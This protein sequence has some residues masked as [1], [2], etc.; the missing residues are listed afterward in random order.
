MKPGPDRI[1]DERGNGRS[2][3]RFNPREH[4]VDVLA[5]TN[6]DH[7]AARFKTVRLQPF[8]SRL[9]PPRA[10]IHSGELPSLASEALRNGEADSARCARHDA[11]T[12]L[13]PRIQARALCGASPKAFAF[14][15]NWYFCTF[16]AGVFG[17]SPTIST[18][19][20]QYCLATLCSAI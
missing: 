4:R 3:F 8:D 2:K 1:I 7:I 13:Q 19:S 18:R 14:S 11:D 12:I 16:P 17:R 15:R 6:V 5:P 20:G 9:K 10:D